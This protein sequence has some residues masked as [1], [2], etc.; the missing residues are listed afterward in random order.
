MFATTVHAARSALSIPSGSGPSGSVASFSAAAAVAVFAG[1]GGPGA[2][3]VESGLPE[4]GRLRRVD[5]R[6]IH[7]AAEQAADGQ[8][9]V[10]DHFRFEAQARAAAQQAVLRVLLQKLRRHPRGL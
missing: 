5:R 8:R 3:A 10:A 1:A 2:L 9:L 6:A 7:L 4:V